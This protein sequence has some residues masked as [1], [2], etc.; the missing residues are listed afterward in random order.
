MSKSVDENFLHFF[1][2][3]YKILRNMKTKIGEI[4]EEEIEIIGYHG[5]KKEIAI[6][7]EKQ[8]KFIPGEDENNEDFLGKGIYFFTKNDH[9][10]LWNLKK[11][12][13]NGN[14]HLSYKRY[15]NEYSTVLANILISRKNLLDLEDIKDIVKYNK[16]CKKFEKEFQDDEE[17]ID[18][19][20]KD[21]A[22]INYLYKKGYMD[23]IFA[24]RK[25]SGQQI[26]TKY[27]NVAH[28]LER[29]IICVK[30]DK[31]IN[32]IKIVKNVDI[33]TYNNIKSISF[34]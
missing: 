2:L 15:V 9:T 7:I 8:Q 16:I 22:I 30:N 27:L 4:M 6:E 25:I 13:D 10:I 26:R 23:G 18:A 28:Y 11:A 34:Y 3:C 21:R 32:N 14:I 20:F 31:I 24:V 33:N 17:F 5:T 19:E 12:K 29:E 1:T